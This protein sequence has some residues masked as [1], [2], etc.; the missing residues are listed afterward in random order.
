MEAP[1]MSKL[2][3]IAT[4]EVTPGKRGQLLNALTSHKA[5]CLRDESGTLQFEILQPHE[6]ETHVLLYEVY[7]DDAA[8]EMHRNGTSIA[9]FREETVGIVAALRV[10]K[11]VLE[12]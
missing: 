1:T 11:C 3:I 5:R 4:V 9:R 6:D 10:T 12:A 2:A 8:F 7:E